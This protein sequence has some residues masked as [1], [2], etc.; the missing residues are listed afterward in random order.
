MITINK[1]NVTVLNDGG[2]RLGHFNT[3]LMCKI[4]SVQKN[5]LKLMLLL[6]HLYIGGLNIK[7]FIKI[8]NIK[9]M[10]YCLIIKH[11]G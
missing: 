8:K 10:M 11:I 5:R 1:T 9:M 6:Q 7:I 3:D 2:K 4:I